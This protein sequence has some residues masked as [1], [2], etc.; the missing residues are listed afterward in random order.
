MT[1]ALRS[2][3]RRPALVAWLSALELALAWLLARTVERVLA[4]P[5]RAHPDGLDALAIDGG[6]GLFDYVHRSASALDRAAWIAVASLG[7]WSLA[8]DVLVRP[9]ILRALGTREPLAT[10]VRAGLRAAPT[11]V[12]S[13]AI[14]GLVGFA[15][16]RTAGVVCQRLFVASQNVSDPRWA[17][18]LWVVSLGLAA[19]LVVLAGIFDDLA[20]RNATTGLSPLQ[21]WTTATAQFTRA[22]ATLLVGRLSCLVLSVLLAALGARVA[23]EFAESSGTTL[24]TTVLLAFVR[25]TVRLVWLATVAHTSV[26]RA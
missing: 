2:L 21:S 4:A 26:E 25:G 11:A 15:A 9:T 6:R 12:L 22:P 23:L 3:V 10:S 24:G 20:V 1:H 14:V 17:D 18:A 13:L 19:F 16:F 5:L 7:V 8:T